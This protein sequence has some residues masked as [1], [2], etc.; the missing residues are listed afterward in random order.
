MDMISKAEKESLKAIIADTVTLLCKNG[1]NAKFSKNFCIDGLIGITLDEE[2]LMLVSI[3]ELVQ[4]PNPP[5]ENSSDGES[6]TEDGSKLGSARKRKRNKRRLSRDSFS[7]TSSVSRL[8]DTPGSTPAKR[9][10]FSHGDNGTGDGS[11]FSQTSG[12]ADSYNLTLQDIK[13]DESDDDLIEIIKEEPGLTIP[14]GS[15]ARPHIVSIQ[16]MPQGVPQPLPSFGMQPQHSQYMGMPQSASNM[17]PGISMPPGQMPL[18]A[19]NYDDLMSVRN[20]LTIKK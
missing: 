17:P 7:D 1:L 2:E 5:P 15:G 4:N 3:K 14:D 8:N 13:H 18:E 20:T 12:E 6:G 16:T 9:G 19:G 10:H 11:F